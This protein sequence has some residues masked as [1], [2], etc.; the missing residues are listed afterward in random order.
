MQ[1]QGLDRVLVMHG[2]HHASH[3][4]LRTVA[5]MQHASDKNRYA[6]ESPAQRAHPRTHVLQLQHTECAA[7][8]TDI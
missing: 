5:T 3:L 8:G 6:Q 2:K 4:G 1:E 7:C